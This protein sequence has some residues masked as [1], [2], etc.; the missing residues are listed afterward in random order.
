MLMLAFP[1]KRAGW[2]QPRRLTS[3]AGSRVNGN[4]FYSTVAYF[5]AGRLER[6][7]FR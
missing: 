6:Y 1:D 7:L 5:G 3:P 4:W 2:Y